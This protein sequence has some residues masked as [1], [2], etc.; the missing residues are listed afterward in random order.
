M[1][2]ERV[3]SEASPIPALQKGTRIERAFLPKVRTVTERTADLPERAQRLV[4]RAERWIERRE[5]DVAE[6][7][8]TEALEIAPQHFEVLRLL[9]VTQHVRQRYPQAIALLRRAA[10]VAPGDA[11]IQNNLGSALA[12]AGDMEGAIAA[13]RRATELSPA[14]PTSWFNLGKAYTATLRHD[15]AEAAYA[16]AIAVDPEGFPAH[17]QR[18]NALRAAGRIDESEAAFRRAIELAP[19]SAEAWAGLAGL[20]PARLTDADLARI[21]ALYARKDLTTASHCL[22]GL[23]YALALEARGRYQEAFDTTLAVHAIRRRQ[24]RWDAAGASRITDE[25]AEAFAAVPAGAHDASLGHEVI[26]LVGMPRSGSTLAEQ[27]LAAHPDVE[28]AGELNV[29]PEILRE[30][31]ARRGVDF[32]KWIGAATPADFARLGEEYLARTARWRTSR[33]RSTDKNLQNWQLVGAIRAML[34]GARIVD[35]RRDALEASWSALKLQFGNA[36]PFTGGIDEI[37]SWRRDYEKLMKHW[38]TIAPGAV[39]HFDYEALLDEPEARI[40]ALLDFCNLEF[41]DAVLAFQDA[42]RDVHTASAV[43][44]RAPLRRDTA[45]ASRYGAVLD[46]LRAAL[47]TGR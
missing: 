1:A 27:I 18:A 46:P 10:E 9:A 34:P 5:F 26:F 3:E 44:V 33:A 13:F 35:C 15:E 36:L 17:V 7:T 12:E 19:T 11:L 40:R 16:R 20:D 28:G 43:Q 31:S 47:G 39:L 4:A 23:A 38:D 37:A 25:I 24:T 32:P 21:E 14:I 29:L 22:F 42:E 2:N 45:R 41:D 30:E 8:L 6:K